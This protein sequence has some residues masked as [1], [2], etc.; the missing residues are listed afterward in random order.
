MKIVTYN[1]RCVWDKWDG[2]NSFIH[3][4]GMIYEKISAEMPDVIAFQEVVEKSRDFLIKMFPEYA[5]YGHFR[6]EDYSGEGVFTAIK[7]DSVEVL[8]YENFW[9]S[10]TPYIAGSRYENQSPCPRTCL[11]VTLRHKKSGKVMRIYNTHLDHISDEARQ[12]GMDG[13]LEAI[14]K[15]NQNAEYPFV[16]LGDFNAHPSDG[17]IKKCDNFKNPE[18]TDITKDIP[19]TFHDF[20]KKQE[21]IDYI[22]M[23]TD[24]KK[25][26]KEVYVWDDVYIW[27]KDVYHGSQ[28]PAIYLS[29]H[30]PI[31]AELD[32]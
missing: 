5:F 30:Y 15:N 13:I 20:G 24:L 28:V 21:K 2:V 1:L 29:D 3:R 26:L 31:C 32:I 18:I 10:P 8:G 17:V 4:A 16:L 19:Y 11:V 22:Y 9:L 14:I 27:H 25:N 6:N 12:N 23:T 7:K